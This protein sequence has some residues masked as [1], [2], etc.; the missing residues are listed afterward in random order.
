MAENDQ[1]EISVKSVE[2][3]EK[4][5]GTGEIAVVYQGRAEETKT[6]EPFVSDDFWDI[7]DCCKRISGQIV[8]NEFRPNSGVNFEFNIV[9][10]KGISIWH[11]KPHNFIKMPLCMNMDWTC[12]HLQNNYK[13]YMT[14][15]MI[16]LPEEFYLVEGRVPTQKLAELLMDS[17]TS[18]LE[19]IGLLFL[20]RERMGAAHH[21]E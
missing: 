12:N 11:T 18:G 16:E 21:M 14:L 4:E 17:M 5:D 6:V 15:G 2:V 3:T 1:Y 7:F 13:S 8:M 10:E 19:F 20:Q 9:D